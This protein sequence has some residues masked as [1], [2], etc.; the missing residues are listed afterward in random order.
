MAEGKAVK[1][2]SRKRLPKPAFYLLELGT[3]ILLNFEL[4]GYPEY[5]LE[6]IITYM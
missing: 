6:Y 5:E 3:E 1:S 2:K 4:F